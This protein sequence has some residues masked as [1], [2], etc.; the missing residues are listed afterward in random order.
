MSP[1]SLGPRTDI[2]VLSHVDSEGQ[3]V[4][5]IWDARPRSASINRRPDGFRVR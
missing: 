5:V 4:D 2:A 1:H 3:I